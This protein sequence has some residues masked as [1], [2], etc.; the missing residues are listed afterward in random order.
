MI[1]WAWD[2]E[3]TVE[4]ELTDV[5]IVPSEDL[6]YGSDPILVRVLRPTR[7]PPLYDIKRDG[8]KTVEILLPAGCTGNKQW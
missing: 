5:E 7:R 2:E 3:P 4:L 1:A 8:H 6:A